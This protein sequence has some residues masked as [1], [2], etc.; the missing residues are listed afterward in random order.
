[1]SRPAVCGAYLELGSSSSHWTNSTCTT[2][3]DNEV[4]LFCK[5]SI[6]FTF[7][8]LSL[9]HVWLPVLFTLGLEWQALYLYVAVKSLATL[10]DGSVRHHHMDT[11]VLCAELGWR[12]M[13][14]FRC[15]VKDKV[16]RVS[17]KSVV[18]FMRHFAKAT[19][20][21]AHSDK[22]KNV[23]PR[24]RYTWFSWLEEKTGSRTF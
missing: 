18:Y 4:F 8:M 16:L 15:I 13:L 2:R 23:I 1:M 10:T 3:Q 20:K 24:W 21:W 22:S 9:H 11:S 12:Q 14:T 6:L 5:T 17:T 7:I 19:D